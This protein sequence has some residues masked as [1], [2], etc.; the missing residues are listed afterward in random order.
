MF[1][2]SLWC[3]HKI[4][5]GFIFQKQTFSSSTLV[6][7]WFWENEPVAFFFFTH[8]ITA[9]NYL[10]DSSW[11]RWTTHTLE[12]TRLLRIRYHA[13]VQCVTFVPH[14]PHTLPWFT[15]NFSDHT[16]NFRWCV[17][18]RR[19]DPLSCNLSPTFFSVDLQLL[20]RRFPEE[21]RPSI[22]GFISL[23]IY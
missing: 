4:S 11:Q 22:T 6:L 3:T 16:H 18:Q 7:T 19:L 15:D 5:L 17:Y 13:A 23:L 8:A 2:A 12:K 10:K 21:F 9:G 14:P 1:E 20:T